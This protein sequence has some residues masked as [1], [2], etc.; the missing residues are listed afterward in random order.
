MR[1]L[2]PSLLFRHASLSQAFNEHVT[3]SKR[4]NACDAMAQWNASQS[5]LLA[6]VHLSFINQPK[7]TAATYKCAIIANKVRHMPGSICGGTRELLEIS[8]LPAAPIHGRQCR[9]LRT[10]PTGSCGVH[11]PS[12][13][14]PH[15]NVQRERS[16]RPYIVCPKAQFG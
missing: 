3:V 4:L 5:F 16:A 6:Q 7:M 12:R 10:C 2:L 9:A 11:D 14:L 15:R 1:R 13:I 8:V